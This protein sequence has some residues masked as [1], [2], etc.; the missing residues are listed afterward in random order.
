MLNSKNISNQ[1]CHKLSD[2]ARAKA[3]EIGVPMVIAFASGR[4]ELLYLE[5]MDGALPVSTD[6][7]AGKAFTAAALRKPTHKLAEISQP[8]TALYGIEASNNGKI[9]VFGGGYPLE[10]NGEVVGGVGISGGSV[11]DDMIVAEAAVSLFAQLSQ[12]FG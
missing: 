12:N 9:V 2:A 5:V 3:V 1:I 6:I 11:E 7:A 4:G 8:G 10:L